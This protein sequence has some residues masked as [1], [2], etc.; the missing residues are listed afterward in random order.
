MVS[1]HIIELLDVSE[2]TAMCAAAFLR[3]LR[4]RSSLVPNQGEMNN[5]NFGTLYGSPRI[6]TERN[7][8][9]DW[10]HGLRGVAFIFTR[11]PMEQKCPFHSPTKQE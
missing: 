7:W 11:Y 4:M 8:S 3:L 10:L 2:L 9:F 1:S 6:N 5:D